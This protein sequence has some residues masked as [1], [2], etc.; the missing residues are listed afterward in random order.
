MVRFQ[1]DNT[2]FYFLL[3]ALLLASLIAQAQK[4]T[5]SKDKLAPENKTFTTDY[6]K[7]TPSLDSSNM[8]FI[9]KLVAIAWQ[10]YPQNKVLQSR[11]KI[12]QMNKGLAA[13]T[14][15][16]DLNLSTQYL[17]VQDPNQPANVILVP[18][19]GFSVGIN[20]GS[21]INTPTRIK[22]AKEEINQAEENVNLQRLFIR[23]EVTRRYNMYRMSQVLWQQ[24]AQA[25][26][27]ARTATVLLKRKFELGEVP[28]TDYTRTL[29]DLQMMQERAVNAEAA[30]YE[31]KA[32][33]EELLGVEDISK[34]K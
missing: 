9:E 32:S 23:G 5:K 22:I 29:A 11:V 16:N 34:V 15:L 30:W 4:S 17:S 33:L 18:R 10:N 6:S 7:I 3:A 13:R 19:L 27:D 14:F 8:K 28:I 21:I 12:A 31:N 2:K 24:N 1:I 20:L 25:V 26:E